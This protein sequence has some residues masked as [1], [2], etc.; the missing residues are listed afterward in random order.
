MGKGGPQ[1]LLE[2]K[3]QPASGRQG[4]VLVHPQSL[5]TPGLVCLHSRCKVYKKPSELDLLPTCKISVV[6]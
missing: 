6:Q 5:D 2:A 3:L 1:K 4:D